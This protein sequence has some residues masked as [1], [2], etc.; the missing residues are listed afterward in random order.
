MLKKHWKLVGIMVMVVAGLAL[1]I[2]AVAN[3]QVAEQAK[4][5]SVDQVPDAVKATIQAQSGTIQEIEMETENGQTV[6]EAEVVIDGQEKDVK[7]AAD[8]TVLSQKVDDDDEE[9]EADDDEGDDDDDEND[10][11]DEDD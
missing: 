6:Y 11:E 9:D 10:D 3:K 2:G 5:L 4:T 7:V 8:G 1:C